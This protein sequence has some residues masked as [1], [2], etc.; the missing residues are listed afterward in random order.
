MINVGGDT[1]IFV[2]GTTVSLTATGGSAYSWSTGATSSQINATGTNN[3]TAIYWVNVTTASGVRRDSIW[4]A[5][6]TAPSSPT[7]SNISRC[8]PGY[9]TANANGTAQY[10]LWFPFNSTIP[11]WAG[12]SYTFY[13]PRD[14]NIFVAAANGGR[15]KF[16]PD[17]IS[18][19]T[20]Q[21]ESST[22]GLK[23]N[24]NKSFLLDTVH[25][26]MA[27]STA[28]Y[29]VLLTGPNGFSK[30][31][32]FS[33]ALGS[34]PKT[35]L[36]LGFWVP[37]GNGYE[38]KLV[39]LNA[40]ASKAYVVTSGVN[41]GYKLP[42]IV[43]IYGTSAPA[44]YYP[45]FFDWRVWAPGC[46]TGMVQVAVDV[47]DAPVVMPYTV[48]GCGT[49][50]TTTATLDA[51]AGVA[52]AN[53]TGT[54][55][56]WTPA[57]GSAST[58]TLTLSGLANPPLYTVYANNPAN[59]CKDTAK[60][61]V[62]FSAPV[63]TAP[64]A[65]NVTRCGPGNVTLSAGGSGQK[66]IWY[67]DAAGTNMIS[68][69]DN[70]NFLGYSL[71][72]DSTVWV[73][74]VNGK[75]SVR[76]NPAPDMITP[77]TTTNSSSSTGLIG[78]VF[79][80]Y[81][82]IIID[83]V[84]IYPKSTTSGSTF[85]I[86]LQNSLGKILDSVIITM[87]FAQQAK[88]GIELNFAVNPGTGYKL[89]YKSL[90][91]AVAYFRNSGVTYPYTTPGVMSITG[92]TN[93]VNTN[94]NYLFDWRIFIPGCVGPKD[95]ATAVISPKPDLNL[96]SYTIGC[97]SSVVLNPNPTP[98]LTGLNY[99]WSPGSQTTP[100]ITVSTAGNYSL[101]CNYNGNV[102]CATTVNTLVSFS[103]TPNAAPTVTSVVKCGPGAVTLSA[104]NNATNGTSR[105]IWF[106]DQTAGNDTIL[107]VGNTYSFNASA[108]TNA[109]VSAVGGVKSALPPSNYNVVGTGL[110]SSSSQG[111]I[112]DV[113]QAVILDTVFAYFKTAGYVSF[114]VQVKNSQNSV[115]LQEK[116][117]AF[118]IAA[119]NTKTALPLN[120]T[121]NPG[122]NYRL[123]YVPI[124]GATQMLYNNVGAT[125]PYQI[126]N[127]ISI[128]KNTNTNY[129]LVNGYYYFYDWKV[130]IPG[131]ET[132]RKIATATINDK[133]DA[134]LPVV[135]D[136]CS[137]NVVL[138]PGVSAPN[139]FS[140]APGGQTTPTKTVTTSGQNTVYCT[141]PSG[142]KDT[143]SVFVNILQSPSSPSVNSTISQCGAGIVNLSVNSPNSNYTY[144]WYGSPTNTTIEYANAT[145]PINVL[146]ATTFTKYVSSSVGVHSLRVGRTNNTG[147]SVGATTS[148]ASTTF[149]VAQPIVIDTVYIYLSTSGLNTFTISLQSGNAT[150]LSKYFA[151][152]SGVSGLVALPLSFPVAAGTGY[153]LT[154]T[155]TN[156]TKC[157]YNLSGNSFP[158]SLTGILDINGTTSTP[159]GSNLNAIYYDWRVSTIGC[160]SPRV[161]ITVNVQPIA[162]LCNPALL[163]ATG[164][165][166]LI[167]AGTTPNATYAWTPS[168]TGSTKTVT[169]AGAYTVTATLSGSTCS[170]SATTNVTFVQTPTIPTV[171]NITICDSG[172]AQT[173]TLTATSTNANALL[174]YSSATSTVV[175]A[176]GGVV[177]FTT[178]GND[179]TV[180]V[181]AVNG[182]SGAVG[183]IDSTMSNTAFT[184][185][186]ATSSALYSTVF[187]VQ[188]DF[189]LEK[190]YVYPK[191][192]TGTSK[193]YVDLIDDLT[194]NIIESRYIQ[195]TGV[196]GVKT[197]VPLGF[198]VSG[199]ASGACSSAGGANYKYY[200]LALRSDFDANMRYNT[201]NA[202]YPYK[203]QGI[204]DI[205]GN[206]N[207]SNPSHYYFFYD[208]RVFVVGATGPRAS[209][210]VDA[211]KT[212]ILTNA[213]L[214]AKCS[215]SSTLLCAG[216]NPGAI[217]TWTLPS[218]TTQSNNCII[219][220]TSGYYTVVANYPN[221][222]CTATATTVLQLASAVPLAPIAQNQQFC[223]S[224]EYT[225]SATIPS[226]STGDN[227]FWYEQGNPVPV[228]AGPNYT[229]ILNNQVNNYNLI[230]T[231]GARGKLGPPSVNV[232]A[233]AYSGSV[234]GT[235]FDVPTSS[236]N[237]MNIVIDSVA[238]FPYQSKANF[239]IELLDSTGAIKWQKYFNLTGITASAKT[240]LKL[241]LVVPSGNNYT[242]RYNAPFSTY[243]KAYLNTNGFH[244][245]YQ[246]NGIIK[247]KKSTNNNLYPYLYD[248][249]V[250]FAG[251]TCV[252]P[253]TSMTAN[254]VLPL[255]L[256]SD[257][258]QDGQMRSCSSVL[259]VGS[260]NA[261][262]TSAWYSSATGTTNLCPNCSTYTVNASGTYWV[263][264]SVNT[265][266]SCTVSDTVEVIISQDVDLASAAPTGVLCGS[267]LS[268]SYGCNPPSTVSFSWNTG[269]T[270]PCIP[271]ST[272]GVYYVSVMETNCP[273][274]MDT[275]TITGFDS[276]PTSALLDTVGCGTIVL[277]PNASGVG[278]SYSWCSGE[279]TPTIPVTNTGVYCV[280][281][282]NSSGC[283][284]LDTAYV[285]VLSSG[286]PS[287]S[288][289]QVSGNTFSITNSS[290]FSINNSY[291][292][293]FGA[294]A[295]P[296]THLG[297]NPPASVT[298]STPCGAG[299]QNVV[300]F[301]VTGSCGVQCVSQNACTIGIEE[302][303]LT[304]PIFHVYPNPADNQMFIDMD[305]DKPQMVNIELFDLAGKMIFQQNIQGTEKGK[306]ALNVAHLSQGIYLL[307]VSTETHEEV[308]KMM[309]E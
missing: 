73:A 141:N 23:F 216:T 178:S 155:P 297:F 168:G 131:C 214:M 69:G 250:Y 295:T 209:I 107:S 75:S 114:K 2:C 171:S 142:C 301:C 1:T 196:T 212:P 66:K 77:I 282:T 34:N 20:S 135:L 234:Y 18:F 111:L 221:N 305:I 139:T 283:V 302:G 33:L 245:P 4:V 176:M 304:N 56:S 106:K 280:E 151:N 62:Y 147:S 144:L 15:F 8:G 14:T 223:E 48:M 166:A 236:G 193:F 53:P 134:N 12:S 306:H 31:K 150:L 264:Q 93:N 290:L 177:T 98:P 281:I 158:Y 99:S 296:A 29:K 61:Y 232:G 260:G 95:I 27:T 256:D 195:L 57:S 82:P 80:A 240:W 248:W 37:E 43:N 79:D 39:S 140:W 299:V 294:N 38:L 266:I 41:Y 186:T 108:T 224:G 292:W 36:N 225:L 123:V 284:K 287:F 119:A 165:S 300:T 146:S 217:Y 163:V 116:S 271:V 81:I 242:L 229:T 96:S 215:T 161:P 42:S 136:T 241:G 204:V 70:F 213:G 254:I 28:Q 246:L 205:I 269:A 10:L 32:T 288:L 104:T 175:Q 65:P 252:S 244:Y 102:T 275:V 253:S 97:G 172:T 16:A 220:N 274:L 125:Y 115:V 235:V 44:N 24:A 279:T 11:I 76:I 203:L 188:R 258:V 190:V 210:F 185:A 67:G 26:F 127:I 71:L 3:S 285:T 22:Y 198:Y 88:I 278:L 40:S 265:P 162:N 130:F 181:A 164:A 54:T 128:K 160:E 152:F 137:N 154:F 58:I 145:Y 91:N 126:P 133:P 263:V 83:S 202:A 46:Q 132:I 121:L 94:F 7:S 270:T 120:F 92:T 200:R 129:T 273:A 100:T 35:P 233:I 208:W 206:K 239:F 183:P 179:T 255:D 60:A 261:N 249:R 180:Y 286:S 124:Y 47:K 187:R 173:V 72:A 52:A 303:N 289:Q 6:A 105:L 5:F 197:A 138:N 170:V 272:A 189:I 184:S 84:F 90:N 103:T 49:T 227:I 307:K 194:G 167:D 219:A 149:T 86:E 9:L 201:G 143:A 118:N 182:A 267:T 101:T 222:S 21:S 291:S 293:N 45:Y 87:P 25:I 117:F 277:N 68:V 51:L 50:G 74:G 238:F 64:V 199:P 211:Q 112:F 276:P 156:G 251:S 174:W 257:N 109:Y 59:S 17:N 259:L 218:G 148:T 169:T 85:A 113:D 13:T 226:G 159:T 89:I 191:S 262:A 110:Y 192:Y 157:L 122:Q 207:V 55:Y 63:T 153:K 30:E 231:Y 230:S 78:S 247:L 19:G 268:T 237:S 228:Y 243:D 309:I 308:F 298:Y